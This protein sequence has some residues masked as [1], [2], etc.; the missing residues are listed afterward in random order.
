[1]TNNEKKIEITYEELLKEHKKAREEG[2]V[3]TLDFFGSIFTW[4][5]LD[6][7]D[8]DYQKLLEEDV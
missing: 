7:L 4:K 2:K 1:M 3:S 6:Q 5:E 8:K